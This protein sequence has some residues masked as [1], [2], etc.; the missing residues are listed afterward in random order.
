MGN[1]RQTKS[2]RIFLETF[3]NA[4]SAISVADLLKRFKDDMNKTTVYRI[5]ERLETTGILH[6]FIGQD[7]QKWF[8]KYNANNPE[9]KTIDHPHF[10]CNA[11][12]KSEC[13]KLDIALPT[14]P[15]HKI[16]SA[17]LLLIGQCEDCLN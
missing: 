10:Q 2:V 1:F 5:L 17:N 15:N 3:E 12:G 6:S 7:G 14:V 9:Q 11:C 8:A 16:D 4:P 13:L